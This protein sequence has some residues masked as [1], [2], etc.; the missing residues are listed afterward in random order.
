MPGCYHNRVNL[1]FSRR[2][3][4]LQRLACKRNRASRARDL[5]LRATRPCSFMW[6]SP[7][8]KHKHKQ[9]SKHS[10]MLLSSAFCSQIFLTK[11]TQL[12][13]TM[14]TFI[15]ILKPI[16]HCLLRKK[17]KKPRLNYHVYGIWQCLFNRISDGNLFQHCR[18]YRNRGGIYGELFGGF[19]LLWIVDVWFISF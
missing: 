10:W 13:D 2:T 19:W 4:N 8:H 5:E 1:F 14:N 18:Q 11:G 12:G 15:W 3:R 7:A 6:V 16:K 9:L 17:R